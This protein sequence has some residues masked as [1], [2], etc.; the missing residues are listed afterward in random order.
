[1]YVYMYWYQDR[2][3]KQIKRNRHNESEFVW[4]ASIFIVRH[5][6]HITN[7]HFRQFLSVQRLAIFFLFSPI[8]AWCCFLCLTRTWRI[9]LCQP[10]RWMIFRYLES[11]KNKKKIHL[12]YIKYI[13]PKIIL[14]TRTRWF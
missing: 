1:M 4:Q 12:E 5:I 11:E 3:Q 14:K 7:K 8:A 13:G 6:A 9:C 2:H 10:F